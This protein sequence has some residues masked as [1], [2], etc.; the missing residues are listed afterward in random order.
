MI[1]LVL[2]ANYEE[3][4]PKNLLQKGAYGDAILRK[5]PLYY[6]IMSTTTIFIHAPLSAVN[7]NTATD[8]NYNIILCMVLKAGLGYELVCIQHWRNPRWSRTTVHERRRT[9]LA[10]WNFALPHLLDMCIIIIGAINLLDTR[11]L[12]LSHWAV[13][14]RNLLEADGNDS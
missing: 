11:H 8:W 14:Q 3:K 5:R 12:F 9:T 13:F 6:N 7:M 2:L 1:Y 10:S 4:D